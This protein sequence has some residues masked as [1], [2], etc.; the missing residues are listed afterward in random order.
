MPELPEVERAV[1]KL[2]R[3]A[4]G[5]VIAEVRLIHPSLRRRVS[6]TALRALRGARVESVERQGKHQLLRLADGRTVRVHFR[7]NGAWQFGADDAPLPRFAR[8]LLRFTDG[9][10]VVL[11]DSRALST[12]EVHAAGAPLALGLGPEPGDPTLTPEHLR[13]VFARR[14]AAIKPVLLDQ[15]VI[16]G[17][18]NIYAAESL[19]RARIDPRVSAASLTRASVA[20]LLAAISEV[21]ASATGARYYGEGADRFDVYDRE[22]EPCHRCGRRIARVVQAGR[23]TYFCP[24]CQRVATRAPRA[25]RP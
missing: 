9:T 19:W 11:D 5:R 6:P 12:V 17:L 13:E 18:G 20:R 8:A 21:I 2:R 15:R 3:A 4:E 16:A 14:R 23:S 10:R 7:M 24:G 25:A 22:D 1:R